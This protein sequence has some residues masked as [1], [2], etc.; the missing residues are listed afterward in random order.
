MGIFVAWFS[1]IAPLLLW[2]VATVALILTAPFWLMLPTC[3]VV[4]NT[5]AI[6]WLSVLPWIYAFT[7]VP[8]IGLGAIIFGLYRYS[9]RFDFSAIL[10]NL[11]VSTVGGLAAAYRFTK[12]F[13]LNIDNIVIASAVFGILFITIG[14]ATVIARPLSRPK[15]APSSP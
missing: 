14:L 12:A 6:Q 9:G 3:C 5:L 7:T 11:I 2:L 8:L 13:L 4:D 15:S 10:P 1:L